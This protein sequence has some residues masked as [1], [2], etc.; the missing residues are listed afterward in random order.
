MCAS[1][2]FLFR[3]SYCT[4]DKM[5][6]KV[7]A[8]IV[9]SQH[10]ETLECHA[11]LCTKKKMVSKSVWKHVSNWTVCTS[12][13]F[14]GH[15]E[16]EILGLLFIHTYIYISHIRTNMN[17]DWSKPLLY[18]FQSSKYTLSSSEV[19]SAHNIFYAFN[20]GSVSPKSWF[21]RLP[22]NCFLSRIWPAHN[23]PLS[24]TKQ[25]RYLLMMNLWI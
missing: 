11:F 10:N 18:L 2:C 6:D 9:Q 20:I 21:H 1:V 12:S 22:G 19:Q 7:F 17:I 25:T 16:W 23:P 4:A 24:L 13:L 8:Y 14:G 5:H 3:I 15:K